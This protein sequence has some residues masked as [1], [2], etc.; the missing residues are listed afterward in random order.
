LLHKRSLSKKEKGLAILDLFRAAASVYLLANYITIGTSIVNTANIGFPIAQL[1][2]FFLALLNL[3]NYCFEELFAL[4]A[5]FFT[6][7][8]LKV[9]E[10][11][12]F[13][14]KDLGLAVLNRVLRLAPLYYFMFVFGFVFVAYAGRGPLWFTMTDNYEQCETRFWF[15]L[16]FLTNFSPD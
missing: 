6:Y 10:S 3:S 2:S 16:F 12:D 4:F 9:I 11:K 8:L 7:N 15:V 13:S 5:F 1:R 14:G